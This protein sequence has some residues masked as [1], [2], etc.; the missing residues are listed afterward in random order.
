MLSLSA[1]RMVKVLL[2]T[3]SML[4]TVEDL[5][6]LESATVEVKVEYPKMILGKNSLKDISFLCPPVAPVASAES[7]RR[8]NA[9]K[10]ST[11]FFSANKIYNMFPFLTLKLIIFSRNCRKV[12]TC[13]I[14]RSI[15]WNKWP[16]PPKARNFLLNGCIAIPYKGFSSV[17]TEWISRGY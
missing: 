2:A 11:S 15:R 1:S 13:D 5:F 12:L 3:L 16:E 4:I 9:P 6:L 7:K 10:L 14:S 17:Q 8:P